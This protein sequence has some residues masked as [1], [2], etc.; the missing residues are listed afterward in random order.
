[1]GA[2][3]DLVRELEGQTVQRQSAGDRRRVAAPPGPPKAHLGRAR[4]Q[5][6]DARRCARAA[7]QPEYYDLLA[8]SRWVVA[9]DSIDPSYVK[10]E[11]QTYL[12]TLVGTPLKKVGQDIEKVNFARKGYLETFAHEAD[13]WDFLVSPN[14]YSS[15]IMTRAFQMD[16]AR[17]CDRVSANDIFYRP[18]RVA[19]AQAARARLG[20]SDQ[21][22]VILYAPT[23]RDDRYDDRGRYI[24]DLK[25]NVDALRE[26]FRLHARAAAAWAPPARDQGRDPGGR[27]IRA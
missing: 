12:Q 20:L 21:Q 26:R 16:P 14:A 8:R 19:R 3:D 22:K 17:C 27:R 2:P 5:R 15:E 18:E 9:N 11:Q 1:M 4:P 6:A 7:F 24:F 25:L 23:W 10:R 13:K